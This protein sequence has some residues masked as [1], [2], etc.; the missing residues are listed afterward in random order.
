M[1]GNPQL[2]SDY[3]HRHFHLGD[4]LIKLRRTFESSPHVR[5]QQVARPS[6]KHFLVT[7]GVR[8]INTSA[9]SLGAGVKVGDAMVFL[10]LLCSQGLSRAGMLPDFMWGHYADTRR[11]LAD[12]LR[13]AVDEMDREL[14]MMSTDIG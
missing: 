6:C 10:A 3:L 12:D 5:R 7:D 4:F 8:M 1:I 9:H 13:I 2:G 14:I 11:I